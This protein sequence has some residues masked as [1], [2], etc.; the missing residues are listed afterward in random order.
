M[1]I[2]EEEKRRQ[3]EQ[4]WEEY[5]KQQKQQVVN[6]PQPDP[7][8]DEDDV[9]YEPQFEDTPTPQRKNKKGKK[10]KHQRFTEEDRF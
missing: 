5:E 2:T 3:M 6:T 4:M 7:I 8:I 1:K 9:E 10:N